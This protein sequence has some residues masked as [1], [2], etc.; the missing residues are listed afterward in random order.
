[1]KKKV[2]AEVQET[3]SLTEST[4]IQMPKLEKIQ[5]G[6]ESIYLI[7]GKFYVRLFVWHLGG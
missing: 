4:K 7:Q 6:S 5:S 3:V 2:S 1:M